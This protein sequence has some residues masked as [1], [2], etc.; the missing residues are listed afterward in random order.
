MRSYR[1]GD[2]VFASE[3]KTL[4]L[5]LAFEASQEWSTAAASSDGRAARESHHLNCRGRTRNFFV[6]RE[7]HG[8]NHRPLSSAAAIMRLYHTLFG[9]TKLAEVAT[10][11][12]SPVLLPDLRP[13]LKFESGIRLSIEESRANPARCSGL[14]GQRTAPLPPSC[15]V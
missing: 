7:A 3:R 9:E 5:S 14:P 11:R 1:L 6:S 4:A 8:P 15:Q 10:I 13:V 2:A 12:A